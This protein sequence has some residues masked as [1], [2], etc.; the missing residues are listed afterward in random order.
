MPGYGTSNV[1]GDV[2]LERVNIREYDMFIIFLTCAP[3]TDDKWLVTQLREVNIPFCSD[4]D[5]A[6]G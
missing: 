2:F 1:P 5:V 6:T 4:H 3:T